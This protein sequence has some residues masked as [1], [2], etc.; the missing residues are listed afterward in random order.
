[1]REMNTDGRVP[2]QRPRGYEPRA[3]PLRHVGF[4]MNWNSVQIIY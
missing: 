3:L 4:E 1:M 2:T